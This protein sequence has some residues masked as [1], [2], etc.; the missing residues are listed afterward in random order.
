MCR[1]LVERKVRVLSR[2]LE[3]SP[4]T[5]YTRD[6]T[7]SN[8]DRRV[9]R[10][11][12]SEDENPDMHVQ[13][14]RYKE[15]SVPCDDSPCVEDDAGRPNRFLGGT[16][17]ASS[18]C[19]KEESANGFDPIRTFSRSSLVAVAKALTACKVS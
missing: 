15:T 14:L 13:L 11:Q 10:S 19:S 16:A 4:A 17:S 1:A 9:P 2:F 12:F 6:R 18:Q 5:S 8:T 3:A 7:S